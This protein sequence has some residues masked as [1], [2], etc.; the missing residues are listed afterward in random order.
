MLWFVWVFPQVLLIDIQS[1]DWLVFSLLILEQFKSVVNSQRCSF[2]EINPEHLKKKTTTTQIPQSKSI[3]KEEENNNKGSVIC[4]H[5]CRR[6]PSLRLPVRLSW[7][8]AINLFVL[9][10]RGFLC[11]FQALKCVVS[12]FVYTYKDQ[13]CSQG[14]K[15][16]VILSKGRTVWGAHCFKGADRGSLL[17]FHCKGEGSR[18]RSL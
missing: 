8:V 9:P 16:E 1:F 6:S 11:V 15:D 4:F 10:Q 7:A 14:C 3:F 18:V 2:S 13:M 17:V 12:V 5:V